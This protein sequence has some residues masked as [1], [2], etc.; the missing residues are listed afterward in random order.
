MNAPSLAPL[1]TSRFGDID[2]APVD[3]FRLLRPLA[4]FEK[5]HSLAIVRVPSQAPFVWLQSLEEPSLAFA[6]L[7]PRRAVQGYG[8]RLAPWDHVLFGA[9]GRALCLALA[10][11][12]PKPTLN[13]AAPLL[14]DPK[15]GVALQVL[16]AAGP[17]ALDEPLP[18]A[19]S[20]S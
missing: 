3:R 13:L 19:G 1:R 9:P 11:F 14:L 8:V 18:L 4:G 6:A 2:P 5:T 15:R 12:Q 16:N 7:E 20:G 10:C 17:Y